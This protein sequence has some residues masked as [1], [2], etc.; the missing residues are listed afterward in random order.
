MD[1]DSSHDADRVFQQAAE[2]FAVLATPIRL[3][4]IRALCQGERSV[5]DIFQDVTVLQ[6]N[7]SQHLNILYRAGV[8]GRRRQGTQVFYRLANPTAA[9]ACRAVC[10]Q[11]AIDL[12]LQPSML[13]ER[14]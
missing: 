10:S 5:G 11:L 3:R 13:E 2:L 7:L 6:P 4:V 14:L 1:S 12:D 9:L 8:V